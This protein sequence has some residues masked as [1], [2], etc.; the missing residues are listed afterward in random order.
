MELYDTVSAS[1]TATVVLCVEIMSVA[2]GG[3]APSERE[4]DMC[5]SSSSLDSAP[6]CE[7]A[8]EGCMAGWVMRDG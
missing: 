3:H 2:V 7:L 5:G 6:D 8:G 4:G 1:T